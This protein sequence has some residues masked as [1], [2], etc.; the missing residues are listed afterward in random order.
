MNIQEL[1]TCSQYKTPGENHQFRNDYLGMVKQWQDMQYE[2]R[3]SESH[4][5]ASLPDFVKLAEAYGRV[6]M[7]IRNSR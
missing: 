5:A 7:E 1:S 4:Y 3:Y 6:G 2:G